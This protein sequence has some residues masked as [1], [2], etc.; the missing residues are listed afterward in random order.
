MNSLWP[1]VS[2]FGSGMPIVSILVKQASHS[3]TFG[4][5]DEG[6]ASEE[7]AFLEGSAKHTEQLFQGEDP[8]AAHDR[9]HCLTLVQVYSESNI[10]WISIPSSE[11]TIRKCL[12]LGNFFLFFAITRSSLLMIS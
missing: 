3:Q 12:A 10:S 4:E 1:L 7:E 9:D 8:R 2:S 6:G 11:A 5:K